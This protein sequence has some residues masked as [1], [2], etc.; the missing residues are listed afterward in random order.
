VAEHRLDVVGIP[1]H[2]PWLAESPTDH[3]TSNQEDHGVDFSGEEV[4]LQLDQR[5]V[6][7]VTAV[8]MAVALCFHSVLEALIFSWVI[9]ASLGTWPSS[10]AA[11]GAA[12]GAQETIKDTLDI[13]I[14]IVAHKGL[15]AYALGSSI[16]DSGS[17]IA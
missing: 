11:Q 4:L 15:A 3:L 17:H 7:F 16:V 14:A 8:L 5:Q 13:F 9:C 2:W 10:L 6:S 12:M 1:H